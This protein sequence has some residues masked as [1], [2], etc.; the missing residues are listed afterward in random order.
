VDRGLLERHHAE[1]RSKSW[2]ITRWTIPFRLTGGLQRQSGKVAVGDTV[3]VFAQRPIGLC[4]TAGARL[5]GATAS[6][7]VEREP[8]RIAMAKRLGADHVIDFSNVDPVEEILRLTDSR[9]VDVSIGALAHRSL[10]R[11]ACAC[12]GPAARCL[13]SASTPPI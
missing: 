6:I 12:L 4:A 1:L 7:A 9:G 3:A 5:M 13:V 8:P 11:P 10:S 2:E